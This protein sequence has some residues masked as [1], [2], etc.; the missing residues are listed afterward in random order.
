[1]KITLELIIEAL[2]HASSKE[3]EA[4]IGHLHRDIDTWAGIVLGSVVREHIESLE[5]DTS[6][7]QQ[8]LDEESGFKRGE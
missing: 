8:E 5:G 7:T 4:I 3:I 6:P 2:E 1:M